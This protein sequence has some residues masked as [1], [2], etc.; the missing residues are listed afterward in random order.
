MNI[1]TL[2]VAAWLSILGQVNPEPKLEDVARRAT[3]A[4]KAALEEM[5][6]A[7]GQGRYE[8]TLKRSSM[9]GETILHTSGKYS[10]AYSGAK[11]WGKFVKSVDGD[12]DATVYVSDPKSVMISHLSDVFKPS[13]ASGEILNRYSPTALPPELLVTP[14]TAIKA[15][16]RL[17]GEVGYGHKQAQ[18]LPKVKDRYVI[19]IER[20]EEGVTR[21]Q[22]EPRN[23]FHLVRYEY[24]ELD[25]YTT[26]IITKDWSTTA[27]GLWYVRDY[28]SQSFP[29]RAREHYESWRLT[30][31]SIE[32][33]VYISPRMFTLHGLELPV[34]AKIKDTRCKPN[35]TIRVLPPEMTRAFE[36]GTRLAAEAIPHLVEKR[37]RLLAGSLSVRPQNQ[38]LDRSGRSGGN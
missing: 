34:G 14:Q 28:H 22:I 5:P 11:N 24:L 26:D 7:K 8:Y 30:I 27:D 37:H 25:G 12:Y 6:R 15:Y 31:D 4:H 35:K 19:Q 16:T 3:E 18:M 2:A 1:G 32:P 29:I 38:S 23:G 20:G 33:N 9:D 13:G 17:L 36:A 10:F 21:Y